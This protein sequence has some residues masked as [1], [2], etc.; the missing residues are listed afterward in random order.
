MLHIAVCDDEKNSL[1]QAAEALRMD[2]RVGGIDTFSS[3]K[4]FLACLGTGAQQFDAVLMDIDFSSEASDGLAA[5]GDMLHLAPKTQVIFIT[6]YNDRYSQHVL[7]ADA[8]VTGYLTKPIDPALLSR[9]LDKIIARQSSRD[10]LNLSVHG[11]QFSI[12]C[13]TIIYLESNDHSVLVHTT[14]TRFKVY[15]RLDNLQS[16]LPSVFVRIHKSYIINMN[17]I[18]HLDAS[19][20]YL[21]NNEVIPISRTYK[22][23]VKEAYF[24]HIGDNV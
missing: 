10:Y 4:D 8:E 6:G 17:F 9:Y 22:T 14:G 20:V 15:G 16:L 5:A 18:H 23:Q 13:D 12:L 21:E 7:L 3:L 2:K 11:K 19:R 1:R 24:K